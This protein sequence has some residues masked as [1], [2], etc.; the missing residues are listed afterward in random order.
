[1]R[2]FKTI[3][4]FVFF[5]FLFSITLFAIQIITI[6]ELVLT[7]E[8]S[9]NHE[10]RCY[11]KGNSGKNILFIGCIHGNEK[12]GILLSLQVLNK[13]FSK[14]EIK[15][16]LLCIPTA[17]PDGNILNKRNNSKN[18]D[19]NRNFPSENW[20]YQD[21]SKLRKD[22]IAFWGGKQ[23]ASEI[24]TNFILKVDSIYNP[25]AII[26][27][28]QF[29]NCVEY[30]G[31]GKNL[32]EFISK[33]TKQEILNDIGYKTSGSIGSYFGNDK[34]KEVVTIEIPENPTDSLRQNI[35]NALV[36][37]IEKGY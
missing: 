19:I 4:F 3:I 32:A 2:I 34:K 36:D 7:R 8:T 11:K 13:I 31:S 1:M 10:M 24:E 25:S 9:L 12:A 27:L 30:D 14:N 29:M 33:Y 20:K 6:D 28:H 22:K 37:V 26:I 15:N 21:S 23:P 18:I 35:I 16:T 17:N 5:L